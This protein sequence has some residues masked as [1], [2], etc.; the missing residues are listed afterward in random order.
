MKIKV[1]E[2]SCNHCKEMI[3]K[4]FLEETGQKVD[5]DLSKKIVTIKGDLQKDT[6]LEILDDIGYEG[7]IVQD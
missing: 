5:V 3:E 2:M 4:T 7:E 1:E 6:A